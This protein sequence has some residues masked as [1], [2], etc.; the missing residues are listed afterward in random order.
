[1]LNQ[2]A[3]YVVCQENEI[4]ELIELLLQA[5]VR[6]YHALIYF[7]QNLYQLHVKDFFQF[8]RPCRDQ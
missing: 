2:P 4:D 1:M 3:K 5:V 8:I 7:V 6:Y